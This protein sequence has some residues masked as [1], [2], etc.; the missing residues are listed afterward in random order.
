MILVADEGVDKQIVDQL[1][2]GGHTV[3]YI[4]ESNPGLPDDAVL[5]IANSH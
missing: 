1:R 2:E 3:V 4:A 5:D